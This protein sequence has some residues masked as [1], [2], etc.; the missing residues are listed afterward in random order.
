[1][2]EPSD[3]DLAAFVAASAVMLALQLDDEA[4]TAVCD[5][6]R[7]VMKQAVLVLNHPPAQAET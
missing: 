5:A 1:M 2:T 4:L 3:D 6:M 7:G